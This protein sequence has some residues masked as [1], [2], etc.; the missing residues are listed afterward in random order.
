[1]SIG[2]VRVKTNTIGVNST[3]IV[4]KITGTD[5]VTTVNLFGGDTNAS[6]AG[7]GIDHE[8]NFTTDLNL[9]TISVV[10]TVATADCTHDIEVA[11]NS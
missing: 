7:V 11:G 4:T 1:M 5:G 10:V 3:S 6:A 2:K 9:T 8:Y